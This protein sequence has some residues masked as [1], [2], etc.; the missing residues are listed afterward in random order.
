MAN[1]SGQARVYVE[2]GATGLVVASGG[3]ILV[4]PGGSLVASGQITMGAGSTFD[5]NTT[6]DASG[7]AIILPGTLREFEIELPLWAAAEVSSADSLNPLTSGTN[8]SIG[9]VN[10]GTDPKGRI[11][12]STAAG[13]TDPVQWDVMPPTHMSTAFALRVQLY[14]EGASANA[15]NEVNVLAFFG[16]G[17]ANAGTTVAL[18]STPAI[19]TVSIASGDILANTP[20]AVIVSP[21]AHA[22]G[23]ITLYGARLTGTKLSS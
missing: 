14:A 19:Q 15:T 4:E 1:A 11:S 22:S 7:G 21:N 18:T 17:D 13:A 23:A 5:L 8:P 20:L 9:R 6:F 2:Q 3:R 10:A 16:V 12:W